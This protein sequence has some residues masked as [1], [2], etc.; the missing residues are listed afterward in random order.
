MAEPYLIPIVRDAGFYEWE[1][2]DTGW[3]YR[4]WRARTEYH[5]RFGPWHWR[6]TVDKGTGH[7]G[8]GQLD[9]LNQVREGFRIHESTRGQ[10]WS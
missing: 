3:R 4:A 10:R 8:R 2:R 5:N 6:Y 1:G 7:Q 9:S